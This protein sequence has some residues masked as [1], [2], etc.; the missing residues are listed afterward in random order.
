MDDAALYRRVARAAQN[1]VGGVPDGWV[2][3]GLVV[4]G[5][6]TPERGAWWHAAAEYTRDGDRGVGTRR[7]IGAGPSVTAAL[8]ALQH[9][10]AEPIA[11]RRRTRRGGW[12]TRYTAGQ[13][14]SGP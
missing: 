10:L 7:L 6:Y 13:V 8:C 1:P 11:A 5:D 4:W 2:L 14:V 12:D 3:A 9:R